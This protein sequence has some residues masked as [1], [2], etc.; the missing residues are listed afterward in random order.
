MARWIW[1]PFV[2]SKVYFLLIFFSLVS[3]S[4]SI[5]FK[6]MFSN[7]NS[8][9]YFIFRI[10]ISASQCINLFSEKSIK[11]LVLRTWSSQPPL[12][13]DWFG[14]FNR[15]PLLFSEIRT[16]NLLLVSLKPRDLT[17]RIVTWFYFV[18]IWVVLYSCRSLPLNPKKFLFIMSLF[19]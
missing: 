1:C 16:V 3:W 10:W 2:F 11:C 8:L 6:R 9:F 7:F 14:Y 5:L 18:N 4:L 19:L 12:T 17:Y 15:I 13:V